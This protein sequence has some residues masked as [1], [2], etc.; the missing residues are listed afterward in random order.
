[1]SMIFRLS[2]LRAHYNLLI[3][4]QARIQGGGLGVQTSPLEIFKV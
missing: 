1:M 3:S 2:P 4:Y